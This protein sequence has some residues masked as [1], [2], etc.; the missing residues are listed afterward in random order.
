VHDRTWRDEPYCCD[1]I[2]VSEDLAKQVRSIEV[3]TNTQA[4]DHQPVLL[5]LDDRR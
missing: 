1:F 5:Q 2:Y 4:S 3:D